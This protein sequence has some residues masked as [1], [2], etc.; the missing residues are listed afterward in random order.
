M[1]V[2]ISGRLP[3]G[4][5]TV[6]YHYFCRLFT[7]PVVLEQRPLVAWCLSENVD[8]FGVRATRAGD[9]VGRGV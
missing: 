6:K 5:S 4:S 3:S 9:I 1:G 7:Y 8:S 2:V